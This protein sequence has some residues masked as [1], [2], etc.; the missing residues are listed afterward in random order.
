[1]LCAEREIP[2]PGVAGIV[3]NG[4]LPGL[5]GYE[6]GQ[7]S[8]GDAFAW[9]RQITGRSL[10]DLAASAERINPGAD[11]VLCIDWFNGCRTPLMDG[12]LTGAFHGLTLGTTPGHLYRAVLE[13]TA[14]GC[15]WI[16]ELLR[17]HGV[18][19]TTFNVGDAGE[20]FAVD[21]NTD[22]AVLDM[23]FATNDLSTAGVLYDRDG[24]GDADD[25]WETLLRTLANDI[26]SLINTQ[27]GI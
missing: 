1:M 5:V 27:G 11:G 17:E 25:T 13:A 20:A 12:S 6:M 7:A 23:L 24:D 14:F 2:V 16:L 21:N 19:V 9:L 18:G 22:M 26:F 3:P 15:R 4:I 8:V 10:D